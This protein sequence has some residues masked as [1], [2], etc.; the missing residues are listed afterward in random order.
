MPDYKKWTWIEVKLITGEKFYLERTTFMG[1]YA[2]LVG[3]HISRLGAYNQAYEIVENHGDKIKVKK[4]A[5]DSVY[6]N[7]NQTVIARKV[8]KEVEV[9][10]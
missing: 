2:N 10:E 8:E 5:D 7:F 3:Q 4:V 1:N 9:I 6:I